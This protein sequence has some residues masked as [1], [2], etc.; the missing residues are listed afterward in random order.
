MPKRKLQFRDG[1]KYQ[2]VNR[3]FGRARIFR[4]EEDYWEFEKLVRRHCV[5]VDIVVYALVVNHFH[6]LLEQ[7]CCGGIVH[8]MTSLQRAY[9]RYF[10][11]KYKRRGGLY[12]GRFWAEWIEDE[13]HFYNVLTYILS[14]PGKHKM[15]N[16]GRDGRS[17]VRLSEGLG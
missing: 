11:R 4:D 3:G 2:I 13:D 1:E 6:F 15:V 10:N 7:V 8:L 17:G 12:E 9:T 5:G 14:N 16:L